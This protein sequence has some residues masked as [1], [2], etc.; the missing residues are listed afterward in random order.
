MRSCR[1][2]QNYNLEKERNIKSGTERKNIKSYRVKYMKRVRE[3]DPNRDT[4]KYREIENKKRKEEQ[5]Q[6]YGK[7]KK[8]G[9]K[10][11]ITEC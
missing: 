2:K 7:S 5:S 11:K 3:N 9:K 1:K 6:I 10:D 8:T 4:Q